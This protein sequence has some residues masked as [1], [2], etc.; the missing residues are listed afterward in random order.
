MKDATNRASRRAE[1]SAA[2]RVLRARLR[3]IQSANCAG[4]CTRQAVG[5]WGRKV[6]A[7]RLNA[8]MEAQQQAS[9]VLQAVTWMDTCQQLEDAATTDAHS[10]VL[11]Q[12]SR[13]LRRQL[14]SIWNDM[15]TTWRCRVHRSAGVATAATAMSAAQSGRVEYINQKLTDHEDWIRKMCVWIDYDDTSDGLHL[16]TPEPPNAVC[17]QMLRALQRQLASQLNSPLQQ[18]QVP[19]NTDLQIL[20]ISSYLFCLQCEKLRLLP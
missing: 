3:S 4:C 15:L 20:C 10:C 14:V 5:S 6:A 16:V 9:K 11:R 19:Y 8:W 2:A 18:P 13:L 17:K 7:A 1:C 12:M